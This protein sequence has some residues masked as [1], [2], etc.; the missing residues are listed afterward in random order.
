MRNY[1]TR[2]NNNWGM[3]LFDNVFDD[4]FA[5]VF[6][7]H[8][9]KFMNTDIV[10]S[11]DGYKLCIDMPGFQ[12]NDLTLTLKDGYL[13]VSAEK[14]ENDEDQNYLRRERAISCK[15]SYYVG[16]AVTEEDVKAKYENGTLEL[17]VPKKQLKKP[18]QKTI[19][20]D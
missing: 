12:K 9:K 5:P 1:L 15:R 16:N 6:T 10:E 17:S 4:F 2:S 3:D 20:I 13:T 11:E 8:T 18:E 19:Q 7:G 14:K